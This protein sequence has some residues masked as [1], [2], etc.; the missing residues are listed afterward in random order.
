MDVEDTLTVSRLN[1][2]KIASD[3]LQNECCEYC[4]IFAAYFGCE[5]IVHVRSSHR[6]E[7]VI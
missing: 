2:R 1:Y 7:S 3:R 5:D 4:F 6:T